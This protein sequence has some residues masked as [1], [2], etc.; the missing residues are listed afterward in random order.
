[1]IA[2]RVQ[3]PFARIGPDKKSPSAA[4][5]IDDGF[6]PSSDAKAVYEI[7]NF[8]TGV[9]LAVFV[10]FV[11]ADKAL[12]NVAYNFVVEFGEVKFVN[13]IDEPTPIASA[14]IR[15]EWNSITDFGMIFAKDGFIVTR[16]LFCFGEIPL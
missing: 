7:D 8:H 11:W 1:M 4:G 10:A 3:L 9:I 2:S 16:D 12:E 14:K 5:W 13:L 15:I 6:L